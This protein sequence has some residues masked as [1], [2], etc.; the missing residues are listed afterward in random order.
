MAVSL[1][2]VPQSGLAYSATWPDPRTTPAG[3]VPLNFTTSLSYSNLCLVVA[4]VPPTG[5]SAGGNFTL[6]GNLS[7]QWVGPT[8]AVITLT[9]VS[10]TG[11]SGPSLVAVTPASTTH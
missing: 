9:G 3:R 10:V 2:G 8:T 1:S 11:G 5:G 7:W 6:S 4:P